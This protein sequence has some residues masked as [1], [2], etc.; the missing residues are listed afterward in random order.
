MLADNGP[1]FTA[2]AGA[3]KR[4]FQQHDMADAPAGKGISDADAHDSAT[5]DENVA[6]LHG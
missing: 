5:D 6:G 3:K 4:F 2:G 1:G